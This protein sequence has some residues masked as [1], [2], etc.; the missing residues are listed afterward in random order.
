[1]PDPLPGG[2]SGRAPPNW[3]CPPCWLGFLVTTATCGQ[4]GSGGS[5][6]CRGS[7][8]VPEASARSHVPAHYRVPTP[9][10]G[11]RLGPGRGQGQA[12]G[13]L[14]PQPERSGGGKG[15][16]PPVPAQPA[17]CA[18]AEPIAQKERSWVGVPAGERILHRGL[19]AGGLRA[20]RGREKGP[21]PPPC[22]PALRLPAAGGLGVT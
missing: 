4:G 18:T 13:S 10:P 14:F 2:P 15:S 5:Q 11:P 16:A 9:L 1:M 21:L 7:A 17:P 3:H 6:H 22:T 12:A 8:G 20:P 19:S